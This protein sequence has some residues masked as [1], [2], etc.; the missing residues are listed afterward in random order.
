M[1][2]IIYLLLMTFTFTSCGL[3][4]KPNVTVNSDI[5]LTIDDENLEGVQG[6]WTITSE[7]KSEDGKEIIVI[8][9]K[10]TELE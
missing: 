8:T 10:K 1:K 7:E 3:D 5:N 4:V 6:E 2:K 9:I